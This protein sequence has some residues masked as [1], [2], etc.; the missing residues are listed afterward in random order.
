MSSSQASARQ[1]PPFRGAFRHVDRLDHH[2]HVAAQR[3]RPVAMRF[4][5]PAE[6][7]DPTQSGRPRR[8]VAAQRLDQLEVGG[9]VIVGRGLR[10][11]EGGAGRLGRGGTL[12]VAVAT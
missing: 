7:P 12:R 9:A 10:G 1:L 4:P 8:P 6:P 11:D 5:T 2:R 3:E